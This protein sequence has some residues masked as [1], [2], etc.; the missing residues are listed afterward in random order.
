MEDF[1]R[2]A[3]DARCN[4]FPLNELVIHAVSN[5]GYWAEQAFPWLSVLELNGGEIGLLIAGLLAIE[6]NKDVSQE[7]RHQAMKQRKQLSR[8]GS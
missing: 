1:R 5:G 6:S 8:I 7:L 2:S 3:N 4:E